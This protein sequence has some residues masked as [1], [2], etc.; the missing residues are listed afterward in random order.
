MDKDLIYFMI[1]GIHLHPKLNKKLLSESVPIMGKPTNVA[2][3]AFYIFH[4]S[5]LNLRPNILINFR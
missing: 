3:H 2:V 4:L 5:A 1:L